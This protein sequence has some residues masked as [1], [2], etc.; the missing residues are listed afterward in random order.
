[1]DTA[2]PLS[3]VGFYRNAGACEQDVPGFFK[4]YQQ[5]M[6]HFMRSQY[7]HN[8]KQT[9]NIDEEQMTAGDSKSYFIIS[10]PQR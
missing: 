3:T 6:L 8:E 9:P 5:Q 2:H 4:S 7:S 1:M 10:G